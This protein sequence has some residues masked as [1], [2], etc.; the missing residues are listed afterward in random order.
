M[1]PFRFLLIATIA[2]GVVML[3]QAGPKRDAVREQTEQGLS[4]ILDAGFP[5]WD[6]NHNG[7]LALDEIN[8]VIENP[9][10]TGDEAA[11]AVVIHQHFAPKGEDGNFPGLTRAQLL[12]FAS[13]RETVHAFSKH[14]KHIKSINHT[15]F[16]SGD[17]NLVTFHQGGVG[18]CYLLS[19]IAALVN[20]DPQMVRTMIKPASGGAYAVDFGSRKV[21]KVSPPT[22][23]ELMMG[24]RE[25][26]NRG[27]WL[28]VLEKAYAAVREEKRAGLNRQTVDADEAVA[29]DLLGGGR[30]GPVITLF[31]G[32]QAAS[33]PVGRWAQED[34]QQAAERLHELLIKL[35]GERRLMAAGTGKNADKQLPKHIPHGHMCAVLGYD[36]TRRMVRVFNPW[37]NDVTPQ[38]PAGLVNGYVTRDGVF[39]VPI[40]EWVKIFGSLAFETEKPA[41]N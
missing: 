27:I 35:T 29:K 8:A 21:V 23:A 33:V 7:T 5:Q 25:G 13:E 11:A 14:R 18:D 32:H 2:A 30:A 9:R 15:L 36:S 39:E 28:S 38:G 26:S 20:R 6:R 19:V 41:G 22:D 31:T 3:C 24:A 37:G 34:A 16:V 17:P 10:V 40:Q 1:Q 4:R 12:A